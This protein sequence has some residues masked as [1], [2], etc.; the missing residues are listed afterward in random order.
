MVEVLLARRTFDLSNGRAIIAASASGNAFA[1]EGL[2]Q[3]Q[4]RKLKNGNRPDSF[5]VFVFRKIFPIALYQAASRGHMNIVEIMLA[6]RAE[7]YI[8]DA[9]TGLT[10]LQIAAKNGYFQVVVALCTEMK[11]SKKLGHDLNPSHEKTGMKALHYAALCGNNEIVRVLIQ[12]GSGC[13]DLESLG[14]TALIKAS[15]SGQ[16]IVAKALLAG[17]AD[18]LVRGGELL[19]LSS[20][21]PQDGQGEHMA[22]ME[23]MAVHHAASNGHKNVAILPYSYMTCG[24]RGAHAL[25]LGAMYGHC[26]VV[27]TLLFH[28]ANIESRDSMG[29]TALH[30]ASYNG[31]NAVIQSLLCRG[32][33]INWSADRGKTA[34]HCAAQAAKI[35]TIRILITHGAAIDKTNSGG[36]TPLHVVARSVDT[37]TVR[38]LVEC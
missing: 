9:T 31:H 34:L 13:N 23:P 15:Q 37:D 24:N 32:C 3:A 11:R 17:G 19:D 1:L 30:Y 26:S 16:A 33:E 38:A 21:T 6:R 28:G 27:Q 18:H 35:E 25:H 4:E 2:L 20:R 5:W 7:A 29:L 12:H 22:Y 14:E 10:S 36:T 8:R